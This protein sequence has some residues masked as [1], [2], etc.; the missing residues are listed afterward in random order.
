MGFETDRFAACL[1]E[2]MQLFGGNSL[3]RLPRAA[4]GDSVLAMAA[5]VWMQP[6]LH[7]FLLELS[8]SKNSCL[9]AW[10]GTS[11]RGLVFQCRAVVVLQKPRAKPQARV[12]NGHSL[13]PHDWF[14][15]P[16]LPTA[17]HHFSGPPTSSSKSCPASQQ[18]VEDEA[19]WNLEL[20]EQ[21]YLTL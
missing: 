5:V 19:E 10:S 4:N 12:L 1:V 14:I 8:N 3:Q 2:K 7:A 13:S 9:S 6:G 20:Q 17:P 21:K 18:Q 16:K 11:R 15:W